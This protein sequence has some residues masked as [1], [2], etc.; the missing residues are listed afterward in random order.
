M[1][2]EPNPNGIK[3]SFLVLRSHKHN[4]NLSNKN[5]LQNLQKQNKRKTKSCS[6]KIVTRLSTQQNWEKY[7][8]HIK[9]EGKIEKNS[10]FR[11]SAFGVPGFMEPTVIEHEPLNSKSLFKN[12]ERTLV[13]ANNVQPLILEG[14]Q[15]T[16][17]ANPAF[18]TV[19]TRRE[20]NCKL[21]YN[22]SLQLP[23]SAS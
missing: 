10:N 21:K 23:R 5:L 16:Q 9:S 7:K 2:N 18:H 8:F 17:K 12:L 14:W 20:P 4:R 13:G 22:Y 6:R 15:G 11:I 3:R 1:K 19:F